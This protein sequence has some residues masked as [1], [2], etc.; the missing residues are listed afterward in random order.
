LTGSALNRQISLNWVLSA[1]ATSY[2]LWRST[3]NG[4]SYQPIGTGLTTSSFVD[5]TAMAAQ[6]NYYQIAAS[7]GCGASANS[8]A[9]AVFLPL[10]ALA[11]SAGI[12]SVTIS[13]PGW[14]SDWGLYATTNLASPSVWWPVTNTVGSSNGQF[15]VVMPINW[16]TCFFRLSAP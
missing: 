2:N 1:G 14:A 13:W 4:V 7:D 8:A 11:M 5:A 6:T 3:N 12:G 16:K 15:N 9:V 10:P